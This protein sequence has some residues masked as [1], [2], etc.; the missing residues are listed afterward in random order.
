MDQCRCN[1]QC[2]C[3]PQ[4]NPQCRCNPPYFVRPLRPLNAF[5]VLVGEDGV[6]VGVDGGTLEGGQVFAQ[7]TSAT[8]TVF[9]VNKSHVS[10]ASVLRILEQFLNR[11]RN[12]EGVFE[13]DI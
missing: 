1:P 6:I 5:P 10:P 9:V 7:Q 12:L 13:I 8:V 2:G 4:C 3:N 11:K